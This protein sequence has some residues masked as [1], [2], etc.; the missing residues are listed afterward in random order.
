MP[1]M[2]TN[3]LL[4]YMIHDKYAIVSKDKNGKTAERVPYCVLKE[5]YFFIKYGRRVKMKV[6]GKR[7]YS[8]DFQQVELEVPCVFSVS[9]EHEK[10]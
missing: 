4:S 7:R 9:S 1:V 3:R 2:K 5:M 10:C 8:K 6:N